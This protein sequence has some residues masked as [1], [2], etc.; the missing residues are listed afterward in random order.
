MEVVAAKQPQ[1]V[2]AGDV[3]EIAC[4]Y[5]VFDVERVDLATEQLCL[6]GTVAECLREFRN[7]LA[8]YTAEVAA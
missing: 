5:D 4:D 7:E 8:P 1:G 2:A 3:V 6:Y